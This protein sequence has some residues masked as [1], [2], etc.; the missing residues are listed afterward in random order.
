MNKI[1]IFN[2]DIINRKF[3]DISLSPSSPPLCYHP[4]KKWKSISRQW[5]VKN[6]SPK[7]G[8]VEKPKQVSLFQIMKQKKNILIT[9]QPLPEKEDTYEDNILSSPPPSPPPSP[10]STNEVEEESSLSKNPQKWEYLGWENC[11]N[12]VTIWD[13][14]SYPICHLYDD[15]DFMWERIFE[16][17]DFLEQ[18]DSEFVL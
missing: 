15:E 1:N 2:D 16:M 10:S 7:P 18:Y 11:K 5:L 14:A 9:N 17:E 12:S 8:K 4:C 6:S 13:D 3:A